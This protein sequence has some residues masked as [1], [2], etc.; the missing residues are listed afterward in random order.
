MNPTLALSLMFEAGR[1]INCPLSFWSERNKKSVAV[2]HRK[3]WFTGTVKTAGMKTLR[4]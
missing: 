4:W 3:G 2:T 1:V